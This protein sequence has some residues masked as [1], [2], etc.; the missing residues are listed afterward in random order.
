MK[1][2]ILIW[3]VQYFEI[4]WIIFITLFCKLHLSFLFSHICVVY[5]ETKYLIKSN[6]LEV[7]LILKSA[8][9][10]KIIT[11][12]WKLQKIPT[13]LEIPHDRN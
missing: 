12:F 5:L 6:Y 13:D 9:R 3:S 7:F 8:E 4:F 1:G 10:N 11:Y 2:L